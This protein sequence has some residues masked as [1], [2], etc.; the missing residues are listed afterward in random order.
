MHECIRIKKSR[1]W[2]NDNV[3]KNNVAGDELKKRNEKFNQFKT[4]IQQPISS[5]LFLFRFY[6]LSFLQI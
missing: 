5:S 2:S 4:T 3:K 1:G 6:R